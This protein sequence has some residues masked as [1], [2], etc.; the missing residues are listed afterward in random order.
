M[1]DYARQFNTQITSTIIAVI[2]A[3]IG[4]Y[5]SIY[6]IMTAVPYLARL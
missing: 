1:I 2:G 4:S 5:W 3:C 6:E